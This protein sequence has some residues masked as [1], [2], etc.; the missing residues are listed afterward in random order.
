[1]R[2]AR[3]LGAV[4]LTLAW[5]SVLPAQTPTEATVI[6]PDV[7]VRSGPSPNFY[8]TSK[9]HQGDRVRIIRED[10][11]GWLAIEPPKPDSF[12]WI[13]AR[14]VEQYGQSWVVSAP[15]APVRIGSRIINQA[16]SV[17]QRPKAVRGTQVTVIGKA[18]VTSDGTWL[19]ILPAPQEVRYI[20]ASA[21]A[22]VRQPA[23]E[24]TILAPPP[25]PTAR[26]DPVV[27][28]VNSPRP[29]PPVQAPANDPRPGVPVGSGTSTNPLWQ[30]AALAEQNGDLFKAIRM[31]EELA[32]QVS[33]TDHELAVR[34]WNK[35]Q[36][37]RDRQA[38]V[39][40]PSQQA[41]NRLDPATRPA[42]NPSTTPSNSERLV[43][44]PAGAQGQ[45]MS[46]AVRSQP[47]QATSEYCYVPDANGGVRLVQP[48]VR[49]PTPP[50]P[51]GLAAPTQSYYAGYL[52]RTA[53][54][55][56]GKP[57]LRLESLDGKSWFYVTADAN[58]NLEPYVE[59]KAFLSGSLAY[60]GLLRNYLLRVT[61]TKQIQ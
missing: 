38:G 29:Q 55:I 9:L 25:A 57:A 44:T 7:E 46:G 32:R 1:M 3:T 36:Y 53:V 19:P 28:L 54:T 8:P 15:E 41:V 16:P 31:Y 40:T 56:N 61:E 58:V 39:N 35:S 60:D 52:S 59:R 13:N 47:G 18:E 24:K 51:P 21:V 11:S 26:P 23:P 2:T 22:G 37:L 49:S 5:T 6:V 12:S 50:V 45:V 42:E 34:A 43:P 4:I 10:V 14:L 27:P 30:E 33:L 20:P 48:V 17:E